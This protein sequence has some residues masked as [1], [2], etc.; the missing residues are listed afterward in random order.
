MRDS[1]FACRRIKKRKKFVER[2]R[3]RE[4]ER[5]EKGQ[6]VKEHRSFWC[7]LC[8]T[9]FSYFLFSL[10]PPFFHFHS[11]M[12][13]PGMSGSIS[14]FQYTNTSFSFEGAISLWL[15]LFSVSQLLL[16]VQD[17]SRLLFL[18]LIKFGDIFHFD[19]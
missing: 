7:P 8:V 14:P 1:L 13:M 17:L 10:L 19:I 4:R 6:K 9:L 3:E 16:S 5:D 15:P 18:F 12:S 11:Y 2:Q